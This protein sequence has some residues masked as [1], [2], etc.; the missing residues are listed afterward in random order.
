MQIN[1]IEQPVIEHLKR[2]IPGAQIQSFPDNPRNYNL[3][4][5]NAAVLVRFVDDKPDVETLSGKAG[6]D[7]VFFD[8][9]IVA[10]N[11]KSQSG[12][13][14]FYDAV[15]KTLRNVQFGTNAGKAEGLIARFRGGKFDSY[16]D[17]KGLWFYVQRYSFCVPFAPQIVPAQALVEITLADVSQFPDDRNNPDIT[18]IHK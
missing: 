9:C 18:V 1:D 15:K 12:V 6:E 4:A 13:Y 8:I 14:E 11:F 2:V 3:Q 17:Q 16:D 7:E 10:R 5:A